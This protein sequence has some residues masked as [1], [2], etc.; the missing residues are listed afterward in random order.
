M[1]EYVGKVGV[2]PEPPATAEAALR[3]LELLEHGTRE[4]VRV[5]GPDHSVPG[6]DLD[7]DAVLVHQAR[8]LKSRR[9]AANDEDFAASERR[10]VRVLGTV[11]AQIRGQLRQRVWRV[12]EV[13]DAD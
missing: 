4:T 10:G 13:L 3:R 5:A 11:R 1:P 8:Q 12:R 6:Q 9:S 2:E 7:R